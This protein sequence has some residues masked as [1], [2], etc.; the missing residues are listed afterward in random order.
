M[1]IWVA[2]LATVMLMVAGAY[3]FEAQIYSKRVVKQAIRST[4]VANNPTPHYAPEKKSIFTTYWNCRGAQVTDVNSYDRMIYFGLSATEDGI[5]TTES[6][7]KKMDDCNLNFLSIPTKYITLR[8]LNSD[9]NFNVLKSTVA[10]KKIIEQTIDTAKNH[11][12][13]GIVLDLEFGNYF[14]SSTSER[15]TGFVKDFHEAAN[16]EGL[17]FSMLL[18]GDTFYR[19]R[20]FPIPE[21]AA[22]AD[23]FMIMA[24]D[25]HKAGGEPGPNFPLTGVDDYGYDFQTMIKDFKTFIPASKL[26]VVFG[27]YGYDWIVDENKRPIKPAKSLSYN[28]MKA[29]FLDSCQWKNCLVRRDDKSQESEVEYIDKVDQYH[30]V[31]F[32][33]LES[34]NRKKAY[35]QTQGIPNI[36]FWSYGYY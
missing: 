15:I 20:P 9:T 1:W 18:Y 32:E 28:D 21:L 3:A 14:F 17:K 30:I 13:D 6:G 22:N 12:F 26:T 24:Y 4:V 7:Y 23:E 36:A 16:H 35:L 31:W 2:G 8:M 11:K 29:T 25:F 19:N 10:Q 27:M 34:V 33:D 5:D